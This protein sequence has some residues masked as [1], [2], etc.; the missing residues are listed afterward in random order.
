MR[1]LLLLFFLLCN[2]LLAAEPLLLTNGEWPP[3]LGQQLPH[4]GIASRIVSEAFALE[5]IQV[6]WEFYPWARALRLAE[7]G[8]RAGSAVWLRSPER[9]ARFFISEPVIES[10]YLLFHRRDRAFDWQTVEDLAGLQIG[11]AIDY[12][13]G[14]A[15][16]RAEREGRLKVRRLSNEEQG[17]R[18]LLAG[19]LDVFPMDKVVAFALLQEHFSASERARLSFHPSP[20]RSDPLHLLLSREMPGNAEL[21]LRFNQGLKRLR[22][23]G[24][25][26]QSLLEM[27]QPLSQAP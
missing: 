6:R 3:Y 15:F 16:Q 13:Y 24:R 5:G 25:V 12:D 17:L 20:L 9:E 18:M 27:Q 19:R 1:V 7:R 8:K 21:I 11:G 4:Q 14:E 23:S 2:R 22:D 10:S 26:A